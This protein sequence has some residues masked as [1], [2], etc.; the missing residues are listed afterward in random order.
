MCSPDIISVRKIVGN[1]FESMLDMWKVEEDTSSLSAKSLEGDKIMLFVDLALT[2]LLYIR[3]QI[4][5][6]GLNNTQV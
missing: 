4:W 1:L 5:L 2:Q 3:L 6:L